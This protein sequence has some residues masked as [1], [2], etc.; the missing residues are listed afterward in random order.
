MRQPREDS[1]W[2]LIIFWFATKRTCS[3]AAQS[4]F[5]LILIEFIIQK[6]EKKENT[7]SKS[8]D[9]KN[10]S[11]ND[12]TAVPINFTLDKFEE[13]AMKSKC[14]DTTVESNMSSLLSSSPGSKSIGYA[15]IQN[16]IKYFIRYLIW[17][18]LIS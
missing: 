14:L 7:K 17:N 11:S 8:C 18:L 2:F 13:T 16:S 4:R 5:P 6:N 9:K 3:E 10:V 12:S 15:W 1:T